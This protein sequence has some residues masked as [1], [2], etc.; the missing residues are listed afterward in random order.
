MSFEK[1]VVGVVG[2]VGVV[3]VVVV[4]Q[5]LCV[6]VVVVQFLCSCLCFICVLLS[7]KPI[8]TDH[9][10]LETFHGVCRTGCGISSVDPHTL[11]GCRRR[12]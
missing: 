11:V 5:F 9:F 10:V 12:K 4:V 8:R 1:V 7:V 2:V 6:V 3:V